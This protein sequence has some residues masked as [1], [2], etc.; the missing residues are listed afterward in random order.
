MREKVKGKNRGEKGT[1]PVTTDCADAGKL[2]F[3]KKKKNGTIEIGC[4]LYPCKLLLPVLTVLVTR[5]S[6]GE[7]LV[8]LWQV[9]KQTDTPLIPQH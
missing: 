1:T 3:A 8:N 6:L 4:N 5:L 7:L 2:K 9:V